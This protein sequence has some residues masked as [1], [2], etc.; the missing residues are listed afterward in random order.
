MIVLD[1][2]VVSEIQ[3]A[4]ADPNVEAWFDRQ[5]LESLW[6]TTV[7]VAEL[8]YG[9]AQLDPGT[10]R[11]ALEQ[12]VET[13]VGDLFAGRIADFDLSSTTT[14]AAHAAEAKRKD[15]EVKGFADAA[16]AAIALSK[17]FVVATRDV[18]PFQDMGVEV[19]DPWRQG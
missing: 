8:R 9:I 12:L 13:Y 19:I 2:N 3:K 10:K 15:R 4:A 17:G 16:I 14:F 5:A 18:R 1:T 11:I 6:L 7:T